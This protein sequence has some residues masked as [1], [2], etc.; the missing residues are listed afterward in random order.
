MAMPF[1]RGRSPLDR[2]RHLERFPGATAA[3][4]FFDRSGRVTCT[5]EARPD[6]GKGQ[7]KRPLIY[8]R[9]MY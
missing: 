1:S 2:S 7:S 4:R 8:V 9:E 3:G 5:C 6:S